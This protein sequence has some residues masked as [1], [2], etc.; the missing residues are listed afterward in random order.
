MVCGFEPRTGPSAVRAE[1]ASDPLFPSSL[2][3]SPP[4]KRV[5]LEE[6]IAVPL[7]HTPKSW[8]LQRRPTKSLRSTLSS[9]WFA[10]VLCWLQLDFEHVCKGGGA[11][12]SETIAGRGSRAGGERVPFLTLAVDLVSCYPA[13]GGGC[14]LGPRLGPHLQP[15]GVQ[16]IPSEQP[17]ISWFVCHFMDSASEQTVPSADQVP[18]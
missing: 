2:H 3:S 5:H 13:C 4:G 18:E 17:R 16:P 1:P 15:R 11:R 14:S 10:S 6:I 9:L 7:S 8:Q 12:G